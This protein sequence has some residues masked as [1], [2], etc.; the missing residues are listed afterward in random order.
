MKYFSTTWPKRRKARRTPASRYRS[1]LWPQ[2]A[3]TPIKSTQITHNGLK[4]RK[5]PGNFF[6]LITLKEDFVKSRRNT[7]KGDEQI[8]EG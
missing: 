2:K 4:H 3:V 5:T 8:K 1:Q 6:K 7:K